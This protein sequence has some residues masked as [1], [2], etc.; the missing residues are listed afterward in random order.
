MLQGIYISLSFTICISSYLLCLI[1]ICLFYFLT[2]DKDQ[3]DL[4]FEKNLPFMM[5][6]WNW[7]LNYNTF[8]SCQSCDICSGRFYAYCRGHVW[9]Y[10]NNVLTVLLTRR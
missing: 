10:S 9:Y 7:L 5:D 2:Y 8:A 3:V 6:K 1:K 4:Y